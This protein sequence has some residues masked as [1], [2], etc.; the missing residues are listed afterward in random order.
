MANVCVCV[1]VVFGSFGSFGLFGL[2]V[3]FVCM[4]ERIATIVLALAFN[5]NRVVTVSV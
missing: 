2:F 5:H 3:L 4:F 1:F